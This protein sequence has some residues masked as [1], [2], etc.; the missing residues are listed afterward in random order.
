MS[1]SLSLHLGCCLNTSA[2]GEWPVT[3]LGNVLSAL[4]TS[5]N[6]YHHS[7]PGIATI[8]RLIPWRSS[9]LYLSTYPLLRGLCPAVL[10]MIIPQLL[11]YAVKSP[12]NSVPLSHRTHLGTPYLHIISSWNHVVMVEDFKLVTGPASTYLVKGSTA[13]TIEDAPEGVGGARWV[14]QSRHHPKKGAISF[15]VGHR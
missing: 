1:S 4:M 2:K 5:G 14:M 15:L 12:W 9:R 3:E 10:L 8:M 11:Q 7:A 13:T 6:T